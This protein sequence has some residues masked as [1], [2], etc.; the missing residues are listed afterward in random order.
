MKRIKQ[1][2]LD[3]LVDENVDGENLANKVAGI[4]KEKQLNILGYGF[5]G[6]ITEVYKECYPNLINEV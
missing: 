2:S 3:I 6:D 5:Q 1:I 4:L